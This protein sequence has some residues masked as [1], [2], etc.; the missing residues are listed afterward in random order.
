MTARRCWGPGEDLRL[1]CG[2]GW[3]YPSPAG[4]SS[5]QSA[6]ASTPRPHPHSAHHPPTASG[7]LWS[8]RLGRSPQVP[9]ERRRSALTSEA[10]SSLSPFGS[11]PVSAGS[12]RRMPAVLGDGCQY[13]GPTRI[14]G[15]GSGPTRIGGPG[16]GVRW[17]QPVGGK[18][19]RVPSRAAGRR[20]S[21]WP[22]R[23]APR[24]RPRSA[25][26]CGRIRRR[27]RRRVPR[28]SRA[29]ARGPD[30]SAGRQ[31]RPR[32][33]GSGRHHAHPRRARRR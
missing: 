9:N 17:P 8:V 33:P 25:G 4:T 27:G 28:R 11:L 10:S 16:I 1:K 2:T 12:R 30:H 20:W 6:A 19:G 31:R 5:C 18:P 22:R 13:T 21:G 3:R 26:A 15:P 14:G 24:T 23:A 32:P 29:A 7:P